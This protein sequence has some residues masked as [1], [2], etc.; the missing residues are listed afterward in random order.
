LVALVGGRGRIRTCDR[1]SAKQQQLPHNYLIHLFFPFFFPRCLLH[2]KLHMHQRRE[3]QQS[4]DKIFHHWPWN[5]QHI[6][7]QIIYRQLSILP[8]YPTRVSIIVLERA[9]AK[10]SNKQELSKP[11]LS[12]AYYPIIPGLSRVKSAILRRLSWRHKLLHRFPR[13][14]VLEARLFC[15]T[16]I[17]SDSLVRMHDDCSV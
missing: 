17:P 15:A 16:Y 14:I 7:V 2:K 11:I 12:A 13:K 9:I 8:G 10:T 4:C 6:Y 1:S 3:G 5:E